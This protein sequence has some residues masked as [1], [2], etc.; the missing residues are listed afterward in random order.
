[1]EKQI[2]IEQLKQIE[3]DLLSDFHELCE[4]CGFRYS[5]GGGT[6]LGAVRHEGF[7]PW[8]DDIDVMMPRPDYNKFIDYCL[9]HE[10]SFKLK[11]YETDSIYVDLSAK[12]CN[13]KTVLQENDI[14]NDNE[15]F[16][17]YIDIFPVDGLG[18]T[19]NEAKKKFRKTSFKRNILVAAQWKKFQKSRTHA[20]YYEPFRFILF[21]LGKCVN[22]QRIFEKILAVYSDIDFNQ[23][24]YVAAVGGS[25]REK[26]IMPRKI[27]DNYIDLQF[28]NRKFKAIADFDIYLSSIYGDYMKLPP[29]EKRVS[30]H[31]FKAYYKENIFATDSGEEND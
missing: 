7:I 9:K 4:S 10:T 30:H 16:G 31:L 12:I 24:E 19:L 15:K 11:S 29:E 25:Y 1:M 14:L 18:N 17:V 6:L 20:W 27:F 8:D 21:L 26:E 5:M 3:F 22:K 2:D 28:E 13:P 23:V